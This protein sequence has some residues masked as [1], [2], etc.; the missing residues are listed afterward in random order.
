M[1]KQ[2]LET[3]KIINTHGIR[4]EVKIYPWCD[5]PDDLMGLET[6]YLEEGRTA[7]EVERAF[8][9]KNT[10]V[11][12]FRGIDRMEDALTLRN[13]VVYLNRDDLSLEEGTYFIQDLLGFCVKDA[14]SGKV[15]GTR[16]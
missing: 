13:K 15:Y 11:M 10:V 2:Y 14:D 1:R 4:G 9:S 7:L 6:L 8:L 12:K 3:G 5:S 16:V